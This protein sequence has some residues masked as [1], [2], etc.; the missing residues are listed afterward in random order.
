MAQKGRKNVDRIL[1]L[2]LAFGGTVATAARAA[3]V[4]EATVYRRLKDAEF[5][6]KIDQAQADMARRT[7]GALTGVTVEAVKTLAELMKSPN[8][9]AIRLGASRSVLE[10]GMKVREKHLADLQ[11]L[12]TLDEIMALWRAAMEAIRRNVQDKEVLRA[13]TSDLMGLMP[14]PGRRG[15]EGLE[16]S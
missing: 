6:R 11:G 8:P 9:P 13:V 4:G 14:P 1:A 12:V 15:W 3:G 2:A 10:I 7:S 16:S 5:C